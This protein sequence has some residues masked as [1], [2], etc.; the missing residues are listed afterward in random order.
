M[1]LHMLRV[2]HNNVNENLTSHNFINLTVK[3]AIAPRVHAS[4]NCYN[5]FVT[6]AICI[7]VYSFLKPNV[8]IKGEF[9]D[10]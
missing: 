5:F 4:L 6:Q 7:K 3:G 8:W 1:L 10:L 9:T 2:K